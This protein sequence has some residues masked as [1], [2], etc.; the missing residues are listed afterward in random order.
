MY[1]Q[2]KNM[3]NT[4][5]EAGKTP[6]KS[7]DKHTPAT[8]YMYCESHYHITMFALYKITE[9]ASQRADQAQQKETVSLHSHQ[10]YL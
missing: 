8:Q 9:L 10:C 7:A 2:N 1:K 5:Q 3:K 4:T 6:S